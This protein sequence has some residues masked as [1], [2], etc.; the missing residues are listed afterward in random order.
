VRLAYT[1]LLA[2]DL[3]AMRHFYVEVLDLPV[4]SEHGDWIELDAGAVVLALRPRDRPYDGEAG[5]GAGTQL[6]FRVPLD[7]LGHEEASLRAQGIEIVDPVTRNDG[8]GHTT[9]FLLDPERN[10]V[11][12]FA[13]H[14]APARSLAA[15]ASQTTP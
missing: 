4:V 7:A 1:I 14:E 3:A 8:S 15:E 9:L 6:A 2:D 13:E 12:L 11:E 5:A 10:V